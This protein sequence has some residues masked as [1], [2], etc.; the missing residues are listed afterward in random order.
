[1]TLGLTPAV[2]SPSRSG[3]SALVATI[4]DDV[5]VFEH[6]DAGFARVSGSGQHA[7]WAGI[8][9]LGVHDEGLV[10]QAWRRGTA[11]RLTGRRLTHMAGPYHARHAVAMPVGQRHVVV[12]GGNRPIEAG[13]SQLV[14]LA[15]AEVDGTHGV[16]ADKLLADEL[17]LDHALRALMAYRPLTVRDTVRHIASVAG[18]ALSCEVAVIRLEIDGEP[19]VEGLDL[20]SSSPLTNPDAAGHLA[21]VGIEPRVELA[22]TPDPDIFGLAV[23]SHLSLPIAGDA[24]GA[25]ALGHMIAQARGFTSLCQRI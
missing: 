22:A 19:L 2:A 7:G 21:A 24:V 23:A 5:L 11:E 25:L 14:R 12:F 18:Q 8:V 13:D 3:R 17:E 15:A 20:R 16:S 6:V 9:E 10:G 1:M 4:A